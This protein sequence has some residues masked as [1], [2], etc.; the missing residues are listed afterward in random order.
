MNTVLLIVNLLGA[1][2][3]L[4]LFWRKLRED[5]A[6]DMIFGSGF[7]VLTSLLIAFTISFFWLPQLWF[8]LSFFGI[9]VGAQVSIKKYNLRIYEVIE[10]LV[11]GFL[12]WL[13]LYYFAGAIVHR[14]AFLFILFI[15]SALSL[16][17]Y[18]VLSLRYK[19]FAWY[20]SGR[21][22]FSGLI[23][24]GAYFLSRATLAVVNSNMI[25]LN[26]AEFIDYLNVALSILIASASF[27]AVYRLSKQ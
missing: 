10:A 17:L 7:I 6:A 2:V 3:F 20:K 27:I 15:T 23:T 11:V 8:F 24:L 5:Y 22:G 9:S 18:I 19:Q 1:I 26:R 21:V 13:S 12:S 14:E 4:F 16:I 25:S